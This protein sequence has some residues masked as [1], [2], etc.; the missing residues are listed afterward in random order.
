MLNW[1]GRTGT[2][3]GHLLALHNSACWEPAGEPDPSARPRVGGAWPS[4]RE[5]RRMDWAQGR[6][7]IL[8]SAGGTLALWSAGIVSCRVSIQYPQARWREVRVSLEP[9]RRRRGHHQPRHGSSQ[10]SHAT[11]RA[12]ASEARQVGSGWDGRLTAAS[13]PTPT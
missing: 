4:R 8:K 9:A 12:A 13:K 7:A 5:G 6:A 2:G 3:V 10:R 1:W 11:S